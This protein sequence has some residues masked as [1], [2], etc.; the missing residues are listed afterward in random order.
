MKKRIPLLV[1]LL[2]AVT[3]VIVSEMRRE[4]A[5]PDPRALLNWLADTQREATRLPMR[6]TR[7]SDAEEIR[8]GD[9][10]VRNA[11]YA[12]RREVRSG[13]AAEAQAYVQRVGA[14]LSIR[15]QRQLP[16]TFHF[17][18]DRHLLNAL[19]LPGGHIFM[20]E[21]LL[22]QL[23]TEDQLA[24]IL[25]HEVIHVDRYHCAERAQ[26][27]AQLRRLPL[28]GLVALPVVLFQAG[29]SKAQ[30]LE[31]DRLG[32]FLMVRAGYSPRGA[33]DVMRRFEQLRG[34]KETPRPGSPQE[35]ISTV[36]RQ[37]LRDYFRS[38]PLPAERI[39]QIESLMQQQ[40]WQSLTQ[41]KPLAL[42]LKGLHSK[43]QD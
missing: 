8:I 34:E 25:A 38:H 27:Q 23:R 21:G 20:G 43:T 9:A 28:G 16:Y 18:P 14:S 11:P 31:A 3:A 32:V 15:A 33:V 30:E 5:T 35:E 4:G 37:A 1:V 6:L 24:A 17:I 13:P 19:A 36:A 42:D 39:A 29:Y 2:L 40:G 41:Q 22:R 12:T 26:T 10:I 7:L